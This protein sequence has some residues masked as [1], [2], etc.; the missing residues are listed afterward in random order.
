MRVIFI[1]R[2][3]TISHNRHTK[4]IDKVIYAYVFVNVAD[5][6]QPPQLGFVEL[7]LRVF[8]HPFGI[9]RVLEYHPIDVPSLI[10]PK[11]HLSS[12]LIIGLSGNIIL[13]VML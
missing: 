7:E 3:L 2:Q 6:T 9:E 13:E 11:R 10:L 5:P 8:F 12:E 1:F 4:S